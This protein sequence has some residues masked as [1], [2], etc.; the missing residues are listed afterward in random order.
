M[1]AIFYDLETSDKHAIGQVLNYSFIFVDDSLSIID[2]LSG[3]V[4][5]SRLQLPDSGAILANR[6]N[7]L[8]HQEIARDNEPEAL[9]RIRHFVGECARKASGNVA[10]IGYNSAKFDLGYLRTSFIRN[11]QDAFFAGKTLPRDLL[12]AVH[13]AYLSSEKFRALVRKQREGEKKLSLSLETVCH[14]LGLLEGV[15]LH[16]SRA[17][18][19]L[20]IELAKWLKE[21]VG[22]DVTSF[23]PY[24]GL[25]LHSTARGGTVYTLDTPEYDLS[26]DDYKISTPVTLLDA[27][28]RS[29]LWIDLARYSMKQDPTCIMWRSVGKHSLFTSG[30][31]AEEPE[32]QRLARAALTQ[33]KG[34]TLKNFFSPTT[35]D[36]EFDVYR[37]DFAARDLLNQAISTGNKALLEQCNPRYVKDIKTLWVRYQLARPDLDLTQ[38]KNAEMLSRYATYRYGGKLQV[39]RAEPKEGDTEGFHSTL[40]SYFSALQQLKDAAM[41]QHREEDFVLLE[42]LEVFYRSS[43]IV[44]VAGRE[45]LPSLQ[46]SASFAALPK[47]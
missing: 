30:R 28:G 25:R 35:C 29:A 16:E 9:E 31:A 41:T 34:T 37:P 1:F 4:R 44:R 22:I 13:R 38:P 10:L 24:E 7:V 15:Q 27:D 8:R 32:L 14:A 46:G 39:S 20:T 36:V 26:Q 33:F 6:T 2:E 18:V 42:A 19:V 3:L 12:H 17:D 45:L 40:Q 43:D 21:N 47:R 23:E 5:I 11:G